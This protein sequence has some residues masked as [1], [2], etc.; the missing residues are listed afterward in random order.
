[1]TRQEVRDL[2]IAAGVTEP[3][4][5]TINNFL[6]KHNAEIQK[7]K[8]ISEKYKESATKVSTLEAQLEELNN[9]GL[10]EVEMAKK[11]TE[12]A[13]ARVESLEKEIA[14]M[15]RKNALAEKGIVGEQA[16]KLF[17][18]DGSLDF[19]ILGQ[20][21]SERETKAK[22][23]LEQELLDK[24]PAPKGGAKTDETKTDI[25]C[26]AQNIGKEIAA[27]SN[28]NTDILSHYTK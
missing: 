23:L 19:E 8:A 5:E 25:E 3:T 10:S 11:D 17:A 24:T 18:E 13:N 27:S 14:I 2:L 28:T 12:K 1:M 26:F 21:I 22:T 16:E 4:E 9:K 6:N 7:E 15:K 20:I